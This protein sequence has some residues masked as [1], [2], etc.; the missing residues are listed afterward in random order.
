MTTIDPAADAPVDHLIRRDVLVIGAGLAGSA[1]AAVL[2]R[3]GLAVT[4]IDPYP[5]FPPL[6]RAEKIEPDQAALLHSLDLLDS[7]KQKTRLIREIIHGRAGRVVRRRAIEQFGISY[8]DIVNQVRAQIP[9]QVEFKLSRVEK[10]MADPMRPRVELADGSMYEGRLVVL[11]SGMT[12]RLYEQLD[13]RKQMVKEDLSMAFGFM[14]ER[15]DGQPFAFDAVTYRPAS[16]EHKVGYVTLFRMGNAMRANIFAYWP[17]RDAATK[18]LLREPATTLPRL[19]PGLEQV[20]GSYAVQ[21][22]IEPFKIDLYR[23]HDCA[24][25]GVV[26][27]GDAYQSV[28]PSTGMGLSKVLNDVEILCKECVP[29]WLAAPSIPAASVAQF[30]AHA[31]KSAVDDLALK[32]ALAGRDSVL[33]NSLQ[34]RVRRL[35]RGWRFAHGA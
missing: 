28:C 22:K 5:V 12:G 20:I 23:M 33:A 26:L 30:Y 35:V 11:A 1:A 34:W 19:L 27:I 32:Q 14:L 10:L 3:S 21:G 24:R 13:V 2:A 7:V 4:V 8:C 6:F 25:P 18:A 16:L 15:T 17:A 31:R 29:R 9:A